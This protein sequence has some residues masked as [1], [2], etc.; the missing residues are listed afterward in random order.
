MK[1]IIIGALLIL[2]GYTIHAQVRPRFEKLLSERLTEHHDFEV[3][4]DLESGQ[5]FTCV[6]SGVDLG[7]AVS[8]FPTGRNWKK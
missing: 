5:E 4:H 1:K 6:Y 3:W 7:H 2:V 8:C